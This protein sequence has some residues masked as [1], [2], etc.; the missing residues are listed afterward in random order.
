MTKYK[1]NKDELFSIPNILSYIRIILIP[2]FFVLYLRAENVYGYYLSA[3]VVLLSG[4][5]DLADGVIARKFNMVTELGKTLDPLADK[6]TQVAIAVM[7]TFR[8]SNMWSVLAL[9]VVKDAYIGVSGLLLLRKGKK[10][11]GA[12]WFGKVSTFVFYSMMFV[13][14]AFPSIPSWLA[15]TM[16]LIT[17]ATLIF[18]FVMYIPIFAKMEQE[19]K[20]E[21]QW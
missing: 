1:L 11:D 9:L 16:M 21:N 4:V 12:L 17:N 18:A 15:D 5:T 13:L 3:L 8:Y 2:V 6:C 20:K 10:L 19:W 14:I 7:L